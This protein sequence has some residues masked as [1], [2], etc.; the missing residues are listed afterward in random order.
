LSISVAVQFAPCVRV[1]VQPLAA[2]GYISSWNIENSVSGYISGAMRMCL[3]SLHTVL[4]S[5]H[6]LAEHTQATSHC[7]IYILPILIS[8]FTYK[9]TFL[10][11]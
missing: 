6:L 10:Q 4:H 3:G 5:L 11:Q 7:Y 1:Y 8:F 2:L 9:V